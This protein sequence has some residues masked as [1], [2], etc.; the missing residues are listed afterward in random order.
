MKAELIQ[1]E[2][3]KLTAGIEDWELEEDI[4]CVKN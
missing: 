1:K 3:A 2:A 4:I